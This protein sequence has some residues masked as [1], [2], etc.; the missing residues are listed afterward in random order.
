MSEKDKFIV[1]A[2]GGCAHEWQSHNPYPEDMDEPTVTYC[3]KCGHN[4]GCVKE[5]K[6]KTWEGFGWAWERAQKMEWWSDFVAWDYEKRWDADRRERG[7]WWYHDLI[8]PAF[9][10]DALYDFF[11]QG[12]GK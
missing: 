10:R 7:N 11:K 3:K 2:L 5:I 4:Y 6:L 8:N 9:F 1:E 12:G